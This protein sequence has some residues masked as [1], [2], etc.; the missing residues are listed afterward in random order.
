MYRTQQLAKRAAGALCVALALLAAGCAMFPPAAGP[1]P[2]AEPAPPAPAP[3]VDP[4]PVKEPPPPPPAKPPTPPATHRVTV[5]VS[6][7]KSAYTNVATE[8]VRLLPD[9]VLLNLAD[10]T[11][12]PQA[13]IKG[14]TDPAT[15]VVVAIGL[16][17][18]I[19]AKSNS[20]VP[21]VFCQVFNFSDHDLISDRV[22]GVAS[23]PPLDLQIQ[24]WK[25]LNP[26]LK[27]VGA[28]LG[29]GHQDLLTEAG[30][31][32]ERYGVKLHYRTARSDRE[33]LYLFN[34]LLPHI[35]GFWLFPDNRVLSVAVLRDMLDYASRHNIQVAVF[36]DSLL[37]LGA[38]ISSPAAVTDIAAQIVA[39][40]DAFIAGAGA[41]I[42]DMTSLTKVDIHAN[43]AAL[44]LFGT[45]TTGSTTIV[46]TGSDK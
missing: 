13:A 43:E 28:I 27:D 46:S 17:A 41:S 1:E 11:L 4:A 36:N 32:T 2:A 39:V 31:A 45:T 9:H 20:K 29:D 19:A 18:A 44:R 22:K 5:L 35:D 34:Q 38:T 3:V 25:R 12:S 15:E 21:V 30:S 23:L 24:A 10:K 42:P 37:D 26:N 7:D 6:D 14:I 16:R 40:V 33:T 8:L